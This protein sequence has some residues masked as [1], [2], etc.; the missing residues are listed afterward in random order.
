MKLK[1]T[2]LIC[3]AVLLIAFTLSCTRRE[4]EK[5][6]VVKTLSMSTLDDIQTDLEVEIDDFYTYDG[7]GSL[8]VS[9]ERPMPIKLIKINDIRFDDAQLVVQARISSEDWEGLLFFEVKAKLAG[10]RNE[11]IA[12]NL[13]TSITGDTSWTIREVTY[14]IKKNQKPLWIEVNLIA[15]GTG[16][17]WIDEIKFIKAKLVEVEEED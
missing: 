4:T 14:P 11:I 16:S 15:V 13:Q 8:Y 5:P 17:V 9:V 3:M 2:S 10:M 12:N 6:Q 7:D 1:S